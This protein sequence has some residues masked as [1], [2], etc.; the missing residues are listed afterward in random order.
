M[1]SKVER[2]QQTYKT[3]F[4]SFFDLTDTSL[5]LA[6]LALEWQEFY[7]KKRPHSAFNGKTPYQKLKSVENLIPIEPDVTSKFWDS[8]ETVILRNDE[9][10][11]LIKRMK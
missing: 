5:D 10:L 7:N 11:K 1:N 9:Y 8:N 4:W 2:P 3:E 6:Y